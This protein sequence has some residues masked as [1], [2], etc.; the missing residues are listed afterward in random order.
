MSEY[1]IGDFLRSIV[2]EEVRLCDTN[3]MN[4]MLAR[5]LW[6]LWAS[7]PMPVQHMD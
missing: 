7:Q 4:D 1:A 3:H 2:I 5:P 6:T